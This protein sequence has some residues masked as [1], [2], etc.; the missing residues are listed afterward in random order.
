M[1]YPLRMTKRLLATLAVALAVAAGP[2]AAAP[3]PAMLALQSQLIKVVRQVA[4]S[5]VLIQN[6]EGL[7]SG[8]I[9]DRAGHI[10][11]NA[12]VV[13]AT[14]NVTV[15]LANGKRYGGSVVNTFPA[16]DL[17]VVKIS[18][19]NLR[20]LPL[21]RTSQVQVGEFA[22]AVGN[23]LGLTSSVTLGIVSALGRTVSEGNGYAL[24][25]AIQTSAPINPGNSGGALV[26]LQGRL[27]G[28]PT[29]A[30]SNPQAGGPASGIG[31][32]IPADTVRS[33][34]SQI[35]K[36][37]K[38][39]SSG[40]AYLGVGVADTM[41]GEGVY[42][43][44]V[45]AGSPAA[46]AGIVTGNVIVSIGGKPTPTV[47]ELSRVLATRKPGQTAKVVVLR[48]TGGR[49]TVELTFADAPG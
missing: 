31:F 2:A 30:A 6:A 11:T 5:V 39:T 9:Y 20:P 46:K 37:G 15:T 45:S 29:L 25:Q 35:I 22:L 1:R 32:A 16:G 4:P 13:G 42:V 36:S 44:Q 19:P 26:D 7:G 47:E 28:I 49:D 43:T 40:R 12:H 3:P 27:I 33:I 8:V 34:A 48:Q 14:K 41:G 24:P 17:A 21:V 18:A 38:V 10:V 23:P